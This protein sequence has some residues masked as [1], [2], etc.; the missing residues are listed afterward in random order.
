MQ[1][2]M[3]L[4]RKLIPLLI[5]GALALATASCSKE[6]AQPPIDKDNGDYI[7]ISVELIGKVTNE[8]G[9]P[10]QNI[11][12]MLV[13]YGDT[14]ATTSESGE[15]TISRHNV[16]LQKNWETNTG[17]PLFVY[18]EFT[19]SSGIYKSKTVQVEIPFTVNNIGYR[20]D[21][22]VALELKQS[23]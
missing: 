15:F 10:V 5:A 19:D 17:Y 23:L 12:V 2:K 18:L 9:G 11:N 21:I 16:K 1:N 22:Q 13:T 20:N 7:T 6:S 8:A 14:Q 4:F 3:T